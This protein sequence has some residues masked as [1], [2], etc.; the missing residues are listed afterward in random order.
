MRV[1]LFTASGTP[2][3]DELPAQLPWCDFVRWGRNVYRRAADD[4]PHRGHRLQKFHEVDVVEL[5]GS[6][7]GDPLYGW[8]AT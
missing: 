5:Q 4:G 3:G 1:Q 6:K 7:P 2:V 8:H